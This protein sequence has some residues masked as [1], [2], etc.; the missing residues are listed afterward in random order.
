MKA[1]FS[2]LCNANDNNDCWGTCQKIGNA[3]T[4]TDGGCPETKADKNGGNAHL[5]CCWGAETEKLSTQI[6]NTQNSANNAIKSAGDTIE[7]AKTTIANSRFRGGEPKQ[8]TR[9]V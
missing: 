6:V 7:K 4:P 5:G 8:G 3:K 9:L 1:Q 2:S